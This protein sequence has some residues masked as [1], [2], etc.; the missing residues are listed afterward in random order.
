MHSGQDFGRKS[1]LLK[2]YGE[3]LAK[4]S[5]YRRWGGGALS[6]AGDKLHHSPA[7]NYW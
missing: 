1:V 3:K 7:A 2:T 4:G 6:Q 5:V